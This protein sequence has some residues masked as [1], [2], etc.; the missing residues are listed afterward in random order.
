MK[1]ILIV[2]D[3]LDFCTYLGSY[4]VSRGIAVEMAHTWKEARKKIVDTPYD[5][6]IFEDY[7]QDG[8]ARQF[9]EM[10]CKRLLKQAP[11][12]FISSY[13]SSVQEFRIL[14]EQLGAS[15][16]LDKP[17]LEREI[18]LFV[19]ELN[20]NISNI[21]SS[22]N[23]IS[24]KIP[25][26]MKISYRKSIYEKLTEIE[27][28]IVIAQCTRSQ[29]DISELKLRCHKLSGSASSYGYELVGKICRE[30]DAELTKHIG[31]SR[32]AL[33]D[34]GCLLLLNS[35]FRSLKFYFQLENPGE[36][37]DN[38][39][40]PV[41]FI[42]KH[43]LYVITRDVGFWQ[44]LSEKLHPDTSMVIESDPSNA[45]RILMYDEFKPSL[46]ILD[47]SSFLKCADEKLLEKFSV[48]VI[49][50]EGN[51]ASSIEGANYILKKPLTAEKVNSLLSLAPR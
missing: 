8:S 9:I 49:V 39:E 18:L 21:P 38:N 46:L 2:D 19:N 30:M 17:L 40:L 6:W 34:A 16:V 32:P 51:P 44:L 50:E 12:T 11:I 45:M 5:A 14:R 7:L 28:L 13:H 22:T 42:N 20:N 24:S 4:F 27:S 25:T 1:R 29:D 3:D 35:F 31:T 10:V 47:Q 37:P 48:A 26:E 41:L 43:F 23:S 15:Y 36:V 33:V